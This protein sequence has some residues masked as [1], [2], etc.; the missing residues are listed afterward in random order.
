V[1]GKQKQQVVTFFEKNPIFF[2]PYIGV[3]IL[4]LAEFDKAF[5]RQLR[6]KAT[7]KRDRVQNSEEA[8][9]NENEKLGT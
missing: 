4:L 1:K 9:K 3:P 7:E 8:H 5:I 6:L 2:D